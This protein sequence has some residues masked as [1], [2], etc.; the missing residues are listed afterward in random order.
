M[1]AVWLIPT[2]VV[3]ISL[4]LA[5]LP[6]PRN[7]HRLT[8]K[9]RVSGFHLRLQSVLSSVASLSV[10]RT[11]RATTGVV[12]VLSVIAI[13]IAGQIRIGNP[14]E[15]SGLFWPDS[16][17]NTAVRQIN[18]HFPGVNTLEIVLESKDRTRCGQ[19]APAA[20]LYLI[21]VDY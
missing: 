16:E 4:L 15:G 10:G 14:V 20:G 5:T 13:Y 18:G 12:V 7:I 2:G 3:L 8:G 21:G 9:G 19:V 1:W 6:A 11:A 17:F